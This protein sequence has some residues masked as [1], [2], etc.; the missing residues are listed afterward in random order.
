MQRAE[1]YARRD[2]AIVQEMGGHAKESL[3]LIN[4]AA[5]LYD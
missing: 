1:T 2:L 4:L 5:L 3:A